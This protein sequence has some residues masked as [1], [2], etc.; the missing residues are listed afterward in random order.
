MQAWSGRSW[1]RTM[2]WRAEVN[3]HLGVNSELVLR[4]DLAKQVP[5]VLLG[6][7]EQQQLQ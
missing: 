6:R 2:R 4:D 7:R 3:K 1:I 5:L